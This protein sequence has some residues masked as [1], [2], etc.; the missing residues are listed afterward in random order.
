MHKSTCAILLIFVIIISILLCANNIFTELPV[1]AQN[2]LFFMVFWLI[3]YN[4]YIN[5]HFFN[6]FI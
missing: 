2:F 3:L 4:Y 1:F 5:L 6:T